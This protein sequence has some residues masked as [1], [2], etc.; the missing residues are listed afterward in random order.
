MC[1]S[2]LSI[3]Q[4]VSETPGAGRSSKRR[5]S[6]RRPSSTSTRSTAWRPRAQSPA[7]AA[8]ARWRPTPSWPRCS[9]SGGVQRILVGT[10]RARVDW[11][12]GARTTRGLEPRGRAR[13]RTLRSST[14]RYLETHSRLEMRVLYNANLVRRGFYRRSWTASPIEATSSSS[15][16]PTDP[17]PSTPRCE[18]EPRVLIRFSWN[19]ENVQN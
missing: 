8:A 9:R 3:S 13:V 18:P 1:L 6:R 4:K 5:V 12:R 14:S 11:S 10:S 15:A 19:S 17:T 7:A 2:E 16:P